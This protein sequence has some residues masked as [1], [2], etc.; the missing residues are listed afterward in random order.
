MNSN[1]SDDTTKHEIPN[2][3]FAEHVEQATLHL[4]QSTVCFR[5]AIHAIPDNRPQ[6][7]RVLESITSGLQFCDRVRVSVGVLA[8]KGLRSV[9]S[10]KTQR[11]QI[12]DCL[13]SA[14]DGEVSSVACRRL[15]CST[16]RQ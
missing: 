16:T 15:L 5:S 11:Q 7:R 3:L 13:L 14:D 8:V 4:R 1:D 2:K 12:L 6:I 10:R 9:T